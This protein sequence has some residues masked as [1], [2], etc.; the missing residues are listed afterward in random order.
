MMGRR[1][2][3][4]TGAA[5]AATLATGA[6]AQVADMNDAINKAGRQRMLSQ[7][8]AAFYL[9]SILPIDAPGARAEIAKARTEFIAGLDFL[10][11]APEAT[12]RIRDELQLAEQQWVLFDHALQRPAGA[13]T[14]AP[15]DVFVASE[16]LLQVMDK[17]TGLY[18]GLKA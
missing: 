8:M 2:L 15:A 18:S 12:P 6:H 14:R 9:A 11:N 17:I 13:A 10:R 1:Q 16:N 3:L 5:L 4:Q 7:R